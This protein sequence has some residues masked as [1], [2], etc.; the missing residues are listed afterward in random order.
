MKRNRKRWASLALALCMVLALLPAVSVP[1]AAVDEKSYT[2]NTSIST[3]YIST[4]TIWTVADGVTVTVGGTITVRSG[5]TLTLQGG[6]TF[7]RNFTGTNGMFY[8]D[9]GALIIDGV[10]IDGNGENFE[11]TGTTTKSNAIKIEGSGS[12][13]MK[14]GAIQNCKQV[15]FGAAIYVSSSSSFTMEGG[16][17]QNNTMTST[18]SDY[19]GAGLYNLGTATI[20]GGIF[21]GNSATRGGAIYNASSGKLTI[22]DGEIYGNT[23]TKNDGSGLLFGNSVFH[24]SK[25]S[26]T[27]QLHLGGAA[28]IQGDI[29][30]DN[31]SASKFVYLTSAL[32][33]PLTVTCGEAAEGRMVAQGSGYTVTAQDMA[34]LSIKN[35]G[36]YFGLSDAGNQIFLTATEAEA[37][38]PITI[39]SDDSSLDVALNQSVTLDYSEAAGGYIGSVPAGIYD[40]YVGGTDTGNDITVSVDSTT[41]GSDVL[42]LPHI[43]PIDSD[44]GDTTF[45]PLGSLETTLGPG[46]Y[47]LTKDLTNNTT[48]HITISGAVNLCL[49]G[50]TLDL[51]GKHI[52]VPAGA[53]LT[54]CDCGSGKITGQDYTYANNN[55]N[56][57]VYVLGGSFT[58]YSGTISGNNAYSGGGVNV[59]D[60]GSFT[61]YGGSITGNT[62]QLGGGVSVSSGSFAMYGGTISGNEATTYGSAGVNVASGGSFTMHDGSIINNWSDSSNGSGGMT[63]AGSFIMHGGE[64]SDNQTSASFYGGGV[65]VDYGGSFT[66]SGDASISGNTSGG[67]GCNVYLENNAVITI[68][69]QLTGGKIG[70]RMASPGMFTSGWGSKMGDTAPDAC[71]TSEDSDYLVVRTSGGEAMLHQHSYTYS[72]SG[73]TITE[74][75]ACGHH[76]TATI[77]APA[78]VPYTGNAIEP[79]DVQYSS[80]WMGGTNLTITY[81]NN[82]NAGTAT[83]TI[84]V[85]SK[86]AQVTFE[87]TAK[88]YSDGGFTVDP[89]AD[90]PY[91][92]SKIEPDDVTVKS[93]GTTLVAGT[94]YDLEYGTNTAAGTDA[95]SVTVKFR[96]NY[97]GSTTVHFNIVYAE[98]PSGTTNDTVFDDYANISGGW[99]NSETGVTF[100]PRDGWT[101]STT[102]DGNYG[103]SVTFDD[104]TDGEYTKTVYVK[105]SEGHIYETEIT[106]KLDKTD[107]AVSDVEQPAEDAPWTRDDVTV[108]FTASDAAAG[109]GSVTVKKPDGSTETLTGSGGE[110]NFTA[111]ENGTYT[112]TVTDKAGNKMEQ[113]IEIQNIDKAQPDLTITGGDTGD[114]ELT[115]TVNGSNTGG[116]GVTVTVKK[117]GSEAQEINASSTV[118]APGTYTFTATTGAGVTTTVTKTVY[119]VTF[120][121]SGSPV[122]QQLVVSGGKVTKPAAP[123]RTGYTFDCWQSGGTAWNFGTGV[124]ENLTLT[125]RW[126]LDAPAVELTAD[127]NNVTYGEEITLTATASHA[128]SGNITYSYEWYK[129]SEKLNGE[130]AATLTL[131]DVDDSGSYCAALQPGLTG[132]VRYVPQQRVQRCWP[133]RLRLYHNGF[134]V[135]HSDL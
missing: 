28:D 11:I 99:S 42:T 108:S 27:S 119:S 6:G 103:T 33:H 111:V 91:T 87:I 121:S 134:Q 21:T 66:I 41:F 26:D 102:P 85:D 31:A 125:A 70:V 48:D 101:V 10:T 128:A 132:L 38:I 113:T 104:E 98:F 110:Y 16:A 106:Y 120:N 62:A 8:V 40:V 117:D 96:G 107:P 131:T 2:S 20:N 122:E 47:Y 93:G 74:T 81:S 3:T 68:G 9:G 105:D 97:S 7:L 56:G 17:I 115:L 76:E 35:D 54:L 51:N 49:N 78:E 30:L 129:G 1:A 39:R 36:W 12:C 55:G 67:S 60:G 77:S 15:V 53:S 127:K 43:H 75:C 72:G 71:F 86:T 130:T 123:T 64:I 37:Y 73:D 34:R 13:T 29:Y 69:G 23:A 57:S 84:T 63:V 88:A 126:T 24:S 94:D 5:A 65:H 79:A 82:T 109:I 52:I 50:K 32:Q 19:G 22:N 25:E 46:N 100:T 92:G 61:M 59:N 18:N 45:D 90:Q 112:V 133:Q 89:I 118:T 135:R 14:S 116:S 80:D 83:A 58:M 114:A 44:M 124:T 4:D 95:G